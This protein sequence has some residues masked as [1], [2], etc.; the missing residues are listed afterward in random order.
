MNLLKSVKLKA[1]EAFNLLQTI[2][3]KQ[4][5]CN[6]YCFL[7]EEFVSCKMKDAEEST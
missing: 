5:Q 6:S 3:D 1:L 2:I 7:F 4:K